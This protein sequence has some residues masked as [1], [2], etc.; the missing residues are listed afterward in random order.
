VNAHL[1]YIGL[2]LESVSA[3]LKDV[4][5]VEMIQIHAKNAASLTFYTMENVLIHAHHE[6][7]VN[8][9]STLVN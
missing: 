7:V 6:A 8:D 5:P 1:N 3:A 4:S 9:L 2:L